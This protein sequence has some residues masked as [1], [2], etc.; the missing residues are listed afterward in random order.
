VDIPTVPNFVILQDPINVEICSPNIQEFNIQIASVLGFNDLVTLSLVNLPENLDFAFSENPVMPGSTINLTLSNSNLVNPGNYSISLKGEADGILRQVDFE[1]SILSGIPFPPVPA[2]PA[3]ESEEVVLLPLLTWINDENVLSYSLEIAKDP[4][5]NEIILNP[6]LLDQPSYQVIQRLEGHTTYYWRIISENAC[7]ISDYS[8]TYSFT[9]ELINYFEYSGIN[10]PL[11]ISDGAPN[12]ITSTIEIIE[13]III[14]DINIS[15]LQGKHSYIS[16]LSVT[17]EGPDGT[18]VTL[19]SG[20]CSNEDDFDLM[21]DDEAFNLQFNC[22][23][24]DGL[25]YKPLGNLSSFND[26]NGKGIWT[27]T[28]ED[29]FLQDGGSLDFWQIEIGTDQSPP[30]PPNSLVAIPTSTTSISL[31]WN[32]VSNNEDYFLL[33]RSDGN[34]MI[35]NIE[36]DKN[37][38]LYVDEFLSEE[39]GYFYRLKSVNSYG[40]SDFSQQIFSTTHPLSPTNLM[41]IP[42]SKNSIEIT[43]VDNSSIETE[44]VLERSIGNDENFS[45][46]KKLAADVEIYE[47]INLVEGVTYFYRT[48]AQND[49]GASDYSTIQEA[50]TIIVDNNSIVNNEIQ[51]FPNPVENNL[52]VF[53]TLPEFNVE[54]IKVID[55]QGREVPIPKA[56]QLGDHYHIDLSF[57]TKG[58]YFISIYG[59]SGH[60]LQKIIKQ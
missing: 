38:M 27:L 34:G 22:P 49:H 20:I 57:L 12:T 31:T 17:L 32:D 3:D 30:D 25:P 6:Q 21:L 8:P 39:S 51:L 11:I 18:I 16:D 36:L 19:F 55:L 45:Q 23:P 50:T 60:V 5:F 26:K 53:T 46:I 47:N 41:V 56:L 13:D 28:I 14:S 35:E 44:Y 2:A 33:E 10:L 4:D 54:Q 37:T 1:V 24:T 40:E 15:A 7:G 58:I 9:T 42:L 43:W 52:T 48:Y 29:N 59:N